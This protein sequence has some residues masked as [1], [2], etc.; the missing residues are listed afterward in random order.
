MFLLLVFLPFF[1][2]IAE[3]C[4]PDYKNIDILAPCS[5]GGDSKGTWLN[6]S[7]SN[8][9]ERKKSLKHFLFNGPGEATFFDQVW[10]PHKC[11]YHR[12]TRESLL[13][14]A[15]TMVKSNPETFP[16]GYMQFVIIADSGTRGMVCGITHII[17]GSEIFGPN[18][19][20]FCG[21]HTK[22][23]LTIPDTDQIHNLTISRY[24]KLSF[25][26]SL[27][28]IHTN[29]PLHVSVL[30]ELK[31][32]AIVYN[33]GC[34][35]FFPSVPFLQVHL[36]DNPSCDTTWVKNRTELFMSTQPPLMKQL[37]D[38]AN[39]IGSKTRL[40]YRNN[41]YNAWYG[42]LCFDSLLE[43]WIHR[44]RRQNHTFRWEVFDTRGVSK[45]VWKE[46]NFDGFH[47]GREHHVWTYEDHWKFYSHVNHRHWGKLEM[48]L[49]QS[50]LNYLFQAIIVNE[51]KKSD[52]TFPEKD[53]E[54]EVTCLNQTIHHHFMPR[55]RHEIND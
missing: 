38:L 33:V 32:Y 25:V 52:L 11:S 18:L 29:F 44:E 47:Y 23:A 2:A 53:L 43:E 6:V 55:K 19:N 37:S 27:H 20:E 50:L 41:H 34:G 8:I 21:N 7:Q 54:F 4:W 48:Q 39:Q 46:A 9:E 31:P 35:I 12:F 5:L 24:L 51:S 13:Y 36:S 40:I 45:H 3:K 16:H 1:F 28:G 49:A 26:Y 30:T 17:G 10:I 42:A 15:E 22:N 14:F